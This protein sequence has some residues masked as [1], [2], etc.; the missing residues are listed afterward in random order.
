MGQQLAIEVAEDT[1]LYVVV[2]RAAAHYIL[3]QS[4][5]DIEQ[6]TQEDFCKNV[7]SLVADILSKNVSDLNAQIILQR[8]NK[9]EKLV[10]V[11]QMIPCGVGSETGQ[12]DR[13][14][15]ARFY[16]AI[17]HLYAVLAKAS[18]VLGVPDT[19]VMVDDTKSRL[20]R[21][22]DILHIQ[23]QNVQLAEDVYQLEKEIEHKKGVLPDLEPLYF[24]VYD[25]S[26]QLYTHMSDAAKTQF[27]YDIK[28]FY[29]GFAD[30]DMP[31]DVSTYRD[32]PLSKC[33]QQRDR[34]STELFEEYG[35]SLADIITG[36]NKARSE[37][38]PIMN[39]IIIEV[40]GIV[41]IHPD[42]NVEQLD[43]LIQNARETIVGEYMEN[44]SKYLKGLEMF[45]AIVEHQLGQTMQ[46]QLANLNDQLYILVSQ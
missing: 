44:E 22:K 1:P 20:Q 39:E 32:I 16:V 38:S 46:S 34:G 40:D 42:L 35:R 41:T 11:T 8:I 31:S 23:L 45:E 4:E 28:H 13:E 7:E 6:F 25:P 29:T 30:E 15:I 36:S 24:D 37:F 14:A 2:D 9:G 33:C 12:S 17:A 10:D 21:I 26:A 3:T 18:G 5:A 43:A 27:E 19:E